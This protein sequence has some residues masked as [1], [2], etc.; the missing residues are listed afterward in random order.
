[1]SSD[2][3]ISPAGTNSGNV[4]RDSMMGLVPE[5]V[6]HIIALN[7]HIWRD[8][9]ASP[10]L[11]EIVRLRNARTV[12]CVFCK[13]VRYDEARADGLT[14]D[15]VRM[16]EDGY[17]D[18][19]LN[20]REKAALSLADAYLGFPC[21]V[22]PSD[23]NSVRSRFTEGEIASLLLALVTFNMTS[24]AA[25]CNGGMPEDPLP[26]TPVSLAISCD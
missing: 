19:E 9:L 6:E 10:S 14:E 8:G 20:P 18:S 15:K 1:M 3:R 21:G 4:I 5:T 17:A 23:V 7:G 24:R 25:V 2:P 16:I 22:A 13:S 12:N 11:L 26:I